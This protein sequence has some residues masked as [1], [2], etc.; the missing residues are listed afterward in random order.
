MIMEW[1]LL[2][3]RRYAEFEGRSRRMEYWSYSLFVVVVASILL[4]PMLIMGDG[5][6]GLLAIPV[7]LWFIANI[8][9]GIA[10]AIR[11]WHDLDQSGWFYLL[12]AVLGAIPF[13]GVIAGLVNLV[14]F[15]M[16]GTVGENQYGPDPK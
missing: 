4:L 11:R 3:Y 16:Q 8:I 15:F 6:S 9:P 1:A 12:F 14:W 5:A 10:V 7:G 2:P 13:I